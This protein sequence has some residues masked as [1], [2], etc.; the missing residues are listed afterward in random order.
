MYFFVIGVLVAMAGLVYN[1]IP[2]IGFRSVVMLLITVVVLIIIYSM[3]R[4]F[5]EIDDIF[6]L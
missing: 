5:N 6:A 4:A 2:D 3:V 1:A